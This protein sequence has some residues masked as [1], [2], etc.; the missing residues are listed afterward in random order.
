M[1]WNRSIQ[2]SHFQGSRSPPIS[3][4]S[5]ISISIDINTTLDQERR[6]DLASPRSL[7]QHDEVSSSPLLS[8]RHR[9]L[10]KTVNRS[11][12]PKIM[13]IACSRTTANDSERKS[14]KLQNYLCLRVLD[15][16]EKLFE[17]KAQTPGIKSSLDVILEQQM[18]KRED[19]QFPEAG[20]FKM[21]D[22]KFFDSYME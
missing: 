21:E 15:G 20:T 6:R 8:P 3:G 5:L 1:S 12:S 4:R 18:G 19:Y 13:K 22:D 2:I 10:K 17:H 11:G 14:R 7:W 9:V 16:E